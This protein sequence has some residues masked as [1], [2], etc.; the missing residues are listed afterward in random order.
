MS[1][2]LR[3]SAPVGHFLDNGRT[4]RAVLLERL[5]LDAEH[6]FLRTIR[7][8]DDTVGENMPSCR[9]YR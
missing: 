5:V 3:C 9:V 7:V 4:D 6:G 2:P 1:A 8:A